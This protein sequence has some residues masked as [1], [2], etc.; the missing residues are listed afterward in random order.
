MRKIKKV[1]GYL[2]VKFNDRE[3]RAWTGTA[4]GNFGVID[5]ELYT[6]CLSVDR[7]VME[8]DSAE[9]LDEAIEQA[10]GLESEID[11]QSPT[12]FTVIKETDTSEELAAVDPQT[13]VNEWEKAL[14]YQIESTHYPDVNAI[15]AQHQLYGFM[16]A[17]ERLGLIDEED[18]FVR[19]DAFKMEPQKD[20]IHAIEGATTGEAFALGMELM[21]ECPTNDCMVFRNTF[22]MCLDLDEQIDYVT[23]L[24]RRTLEEKFYKYQRELFKM[25]FHNHAIHEYRKEHRVTKTFGSSNSVVATPDMKNLQQIIKHLNS[26]VPRELAI[27]H[28][29]S[30]PSQPYRAHLK[31]KRERGCQKETE[32]PVQETTPYGE[33][34]FQGKGE[35]LKTFGKFLKEVED[36]T[37]QV[38]IQQN[39][40]TPWY[41]GKPGDDQYLTEKYSDHTLE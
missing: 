1:N 3:L 33:C 4:L 34:P 20:F 30:S 40:N 32:P 39:N 37:K 27:D 22:K 16:V 19:P 36:Y 6:G 2:I 21:K 25:S 10:R 12:S 9:T 15:T 26:I 29:D 8:Y 11:I 28:G 35:E 17:L 7:S 18:C 13:M 38:T 31:E 5:A 41:P 14:T 24:A 23:G